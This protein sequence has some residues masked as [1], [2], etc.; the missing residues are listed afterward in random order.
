MKTKRPAQLDDFFSNHAVFCGLGCLSS[1]VFG[2]M[3]LGAL[4][5]LGFVWK[6]SQ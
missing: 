4:I 3:A 1:I 6:Y 5:A 2:W